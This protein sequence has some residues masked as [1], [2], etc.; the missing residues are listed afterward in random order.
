MYQRKWQDEWHNAIQICIGRWYQ[1][2]QVGGEWVRDAQKPV[3]IMN[4][5]MQAPMAAPPAAIFRYHPANLMP[6]RWLQAAP[7]KKP[8]QLHG[9]FCG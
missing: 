4:S 5:S 3:W 2:T 1:A 6:R 9:S 7:S 8:N